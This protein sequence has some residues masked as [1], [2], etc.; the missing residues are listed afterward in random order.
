MRR[1]P[2][3]RCPRRGRCWSIEI[4]ASW[5]CATAQM[6]FF[7]PN[8]AS[9]P[10]NTPGRVDAIV[11]LSTTGMPHS[12]NSMPMSR[13]IHG[14]RVLLADRDQHVVAREVD[15]GLAGRQRAAAGPW[16]R[17]CAATFSNV[18][19][20][21]LP[22]SCVI[23]FGTR[24]LWIG[25]PSCAASSFSHGDAFISSKPERTTT[26]T[27]S[28]PRRR[29]LRQQSIAVLPPPSTTTRLP[30]FVVW[31]NETL[32]EPVDADVDVRRG[33][34]A[35]RHVEVAAARRAAADEHRV[36]AFG[37][38]RLQ[39]VD[40]L[41]GAELDAEVEH[42]ADLLVDHRLGQPELRDLRAHHAAGARVAV[43]H[44][45]LVAERREVA[46]DGERRRARRRRARC[47][48]RSSS[49]RAAAAASRMSSL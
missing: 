3:R 15:V 18:T 14:K 24:K 7:G 6:M 41:P 38:Q 20:V 46:R 35:A 29:A 33:F 44:D 2:L 4:A 43:E 9:P 31:P 49:R 21:S 48:C 22:S 13:S 28:P 8:A 1:R 27:S 23:A 11:T 25:M 5:P 37:E 36:P 39:A 30:I 10:K 42:V 16:R 26:C 34:L 45:A 47:A 32:D 17:I 19:P 12:S 40:P